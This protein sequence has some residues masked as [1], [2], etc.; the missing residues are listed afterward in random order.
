[1]LQT[2]RSLIRPWLGAAVARFKTD[3]ERSGEA[4][5]RVLAQL[6]GSLSATEYGRAYKVRAF[7]GYDDF[8]QKVPIVGYD[9][10]EEWI[11]RQKNEEG[12]ILVSERVLFYEKTSGS[13]GPAKYIP[14]TNGLKESFNNMFAVWLCDLLDRGPA[15][16]TG[17]I[18]ISISPA[19]VSAQKTDR[20]V[21]IGLE[22]DSEYL[23]EGLRLMLKPFL[24]LPASIKRLQDPVMFKRAIAALLLAESRLEVVSIWNPTMFDIILDYI[25][26][27][28][29]ALSQDLGRGSV[30]CENI[31]F[32]FKPVSVSRL[33][34]LEQASVEWTAIWPH[35]KL[36]SCWT[37][38]HSATPARRLANRF[39]GVYLQGKGLL[40]TEAPLTFPLIEA[41]GFV[42]LP[43]ELFYEFIDDAGQ[44]RLLHQLEAGQQYEIVV[45]QKGG[46]YRYRI[47]DR[48]KVTHYYCDAPCLEFIGRS[49]AV[50]DMV[51]EKLNESFVQSCLGRFFVEPGSFQSLLPVLS[52]RGECY[53][54]LL[55]DKLP[56]PA[57]SFEEALD[58]A[59]CDAFH[60][61]NARSLGQLG[62]A[63]VI[64]AS[65]ARE[66]Y[67][68]YFTNKGMKWGDIKHSYLIRDI[69]D[70][71]NIIKKINSLA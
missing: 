21:R 23:S 1:M 66:V 18:F 8:A 49:D 63:R 60:Y 54:L 70:A 58:E 37:G 50:C 27:N 17:K 48:V 7:D 29:E 44:V 16:E 28:G 13:S 4:Q 10:L 12:S 9:D 3:L 52:A 41:R 65:K 24:V 19:P 45:T 68:D 39:P 5:R 40:A 55:A 71:A 69:T 57:A 36:I 47:G 25:Q 59:L 62:R 61:R 20:G 42:P 15:F 53:Y 33:K 67:Y 51:G 22:D 35:L 38:A 31:E 64:A 26:K 43:A 32:K 30:T 56:Q 11:E 6:I 14:Y 46:L 34:L 2:I